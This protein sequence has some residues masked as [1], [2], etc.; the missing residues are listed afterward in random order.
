MSATGGWSPCQPHGLNRAHSTA[1]ATVRFTTK[2]QPSTAGGCQP[3]V[4]RVAALAQRRRAV[5]HQSLGAAW[6]VE[7]AVASRAKRCE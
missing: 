2:P 1:T 3:W 4:D 7:R 6:S 5:N